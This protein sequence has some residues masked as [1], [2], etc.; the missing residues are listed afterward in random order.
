M[1]PV[2]KK[3]ARFITVNLQPLPGPLTNNFPGYTI[4]LMPLSSSSLDIPPCSL[5]HLCR[6]ILSE[7]SH[8]TQPTERCEAGM[9]PGKLGVILFIT[10]V[11]EVQTCLL[12]TRTKLP[13][14]NYQMVCAFCRCRENVWAL[15]MKELPLN[16]Y[17]YM[18]MLIIMFQRKYK[19]YP[20]TSLHLYPFTHNT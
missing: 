1:L 17:V 16:V 19:N 3:L 20:Q 13:S 14:A 12:L 9:W 10:S 4:L 15:L 7:S 11:F 6:L 18:L 8:Q 5:F 2:C